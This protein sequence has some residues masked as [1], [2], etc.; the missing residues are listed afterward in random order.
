MFE[1]IDEN[2]YDID[3]VLVIKDG[4]LLVEEYLNE[5]YSV[6]DLH[7]V[8]SV[9]KSVSSALIGIAIDEGYI[10]GVDQKILEFFENV[11]VLNKAEKEN[12]TIEHLL[13]HTSGIYWRESQLPYSSPDNSFSKLSDSP[14]WVEFILNET[15]EYEPGTVQNYNSGDSHLLSAILT[16]ATGKSTLEYATEH[17]FD[18]LGIKKLQWQTD[19][20]GINTGGSG[21]LLRPRGMAKFG[22]LYLNNGT[23]DD[24]QLVP[25][26]WVINSTKNPVE[27]DEWASYGYQWWVY[28]QVN[29][30]LALGYGGQI[31]W[32]TPEYDLEIV[33]TSSLFDGEWPIATLAVDYIIKAIEEGY[34]E[35]TPFSAASIILSIITISCLTL[36]LRKIKD[37]ANPKKIQ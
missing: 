19:P 7:S 10:K 16:N 28:P 34:V 5:D 9:T 4:Y 33:F 20:Q 35:K 17:L 32:L 37:K 25:K 18:P 6:T 24:S 26:E 11:L 29:S 15:L 14:N 8:F 27:I 31:I 3:S 12:I 22:F 23:W 30:Y 36:N 2:N 1:Y 13:T 21:L